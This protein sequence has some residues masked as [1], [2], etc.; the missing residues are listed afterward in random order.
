MARWC[1]TCQAFRDFDINQLVHTAE[2]CGN[3]LSK[4][5]GLDKIL[6][7]VSKNLPENLF[8]T[9]YALAVEVAAADL[10]IKAE[11]LRFFAALARFP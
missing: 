3:F 4:E 10:E 2:A 9:A 11:E 5:D 6:S 7:E 8:E 1:K